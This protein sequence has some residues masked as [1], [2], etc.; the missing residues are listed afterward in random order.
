MIKIFINTCFFFYY[1]Q[2]SNFLTLAARVSVNVADY[3][4]GLDSLPLYCFI[5]S[6]DKKTLSIVVKRQKAVP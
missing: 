4:V 2:Y 3:M 1:L 6:L 5:A